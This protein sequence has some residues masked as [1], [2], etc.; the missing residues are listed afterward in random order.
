VS[1][2]ILTINSHYFPVQH[3]LIDLAHE[4]R[5][6]REVRTE[7][8]WG[9]AHI[10]CNHFMRLYCAN[11]SV[12]EL[13]WG[14]QLLRYGLVQAGNFRTGVSPSTSFFPCQ[15]H[16]IFTLIYKYM[17]FVPYGQR[18]QSLGALRKAVLFDKSG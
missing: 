5:V 18:G 7:P 15:H 1:H 2:T 3:Q 6:L 17:L 14:D 11:C 10:N 8:L 9:K 4:H 12:C 16:A 13:Y